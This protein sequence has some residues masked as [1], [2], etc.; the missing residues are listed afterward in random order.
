MARRNLLIAF[1]VTVFLA[2][3]M[4]VAEAT[5]KKNPT[6]TTKSTGWIQYTT[7]TGYFLQDEPGTD[8]RTFQ[9]V[10]PLSICPWLL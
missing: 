3:S 10:R 9:Y 1:F 4:S 2:L 5:T 7:L 8:A 6:Q